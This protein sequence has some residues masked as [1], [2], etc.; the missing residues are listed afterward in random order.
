MK[1]QT[2]GLTLLIESQIN[3]DWDM[4]ISGDGLIKL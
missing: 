4:K 1:T 2:K 3:S